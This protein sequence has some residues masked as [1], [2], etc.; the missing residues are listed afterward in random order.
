MEIK[1]NDDNEQIARL[2][3]DNRAL[4][5]QLTAACSKL[6]RIQ[7][8]LRTLSEEMLSHVSHGPV[9]DLT[10]PDI[11]VHKPSPD[12][13]IEGA[14]I[15]N[16][17]MMSTQSQPAA[18]S[19]TTPSDTDQCDGDV[20]SLKS[21][22][23][24]E[25]LLPSIF[26]DASRT[27]EDNGMEQASFSL[28]PSFEGRQTPVEL[29]MASLLGSF[30]EV[31]SLPGVWTHEYQMGPA[32]FQA[33]CPSAERISQGLA[34]TNSPFSDHMQM[35]KSCLKMQWRK[36]TQ[37]RT[38]METSQ[39]TLQ[40]LSCCN[41]LTL[42]RDGL[43]LAA[44]V[45]LSHFH[46]LNRPAAL[47]WYT[48]TRYQ[49]NITNL[50]LWQINR[51]RV[52]YSRMHA[53]YRPTALQL[54]EDY[55]SV[56]DWC[57]FPTIRDKLILLHSAN[58]YLDQIICD[59][60]TAYVVEVDADRYVLGQAGH[61]YIRVWDLICAFES[62]DIEDDPAQNAGLLTEQPLAP[63]FPDGPPAFSLPAPDVDCLFQASYARRAFKML[64]LDDGVPRFKLDPSLF[65]QHPELYDS[66]AE[67][68]ATG[69]AIVPKIQTKIPT[70]T[71][72]RH[73]TINIYRNV[74]D[75]CVNAICKASLVD[76]FKA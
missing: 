37:V 60:A 53:N 16:T 33:Q 2:V 5:E 19:E 41:R 59:I 72:P 14:T 12:K 39:V 67:I 23:N 7:I 48:A 44:T 54:L 61:A 13:G 76:A 9:S 34:N 21:N 27:D 22:I 30:S 47:A 64:G 3:K 35:I 55:P 75:W 38:N 8:T 52:I 46:S 45:L 74:A 20:S 36:A 43:G 49:E 63:G 1:G 18:A 71:L 24:R 17:T 56:I 73:E 68:L 66:G 29:D 6:E 40:P 11:A 31:R 26:L 58:P 50:V 28:N 65:V 51:S 70:P 62:E 42:L 25:Q 15:C 57:P 4:R 69:T 32:S 10:T